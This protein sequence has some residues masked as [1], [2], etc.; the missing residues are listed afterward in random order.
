MK[1]FPKAI[2]ELNGGLF[3]PKQVVD[4]LERVLDDQRCA[5]ER[6]GSGREAAALLELKD[7]LGLA[8]PAAPLPSAADQL[9]LPD[10]ETERIARNLLK[11]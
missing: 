10:P 9:D 4:L 8:G 1:K 7:L 3:I 11:M 2:P 6:D 5:L